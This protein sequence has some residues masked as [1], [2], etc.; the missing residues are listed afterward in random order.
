MVVVFGGEGIDE[1]FEF[2]GVEGDEFA[3]ASALEVVMVWLEWASEFVA[4]FPADVDDVDDAE[5]DEHIKCAVDAGAIDIR[6]G[7][8]DITNT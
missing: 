3:A 4:F 6:A 5:A 2:G 8:G 1:G 7:A